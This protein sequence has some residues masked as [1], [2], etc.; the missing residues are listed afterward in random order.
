MD[1]PFFALNRLLTG[2]SGWKRIILRF[3][4]FGWFFLKKGSQKPSLAVSE[5]IDEALCFR[6]ID[7]KPKKRDDES[8]YLYFSQRKPKNK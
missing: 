3:P 1:F 8:F 6:W 7:R 4:L 2:E 5:V